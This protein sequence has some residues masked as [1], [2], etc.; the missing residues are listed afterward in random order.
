[1]NSREE[2]LAR[3]LSD[4]T[5]LDA[6]SVPALNSEEFPKVVVWVKSGPQWAT[7]K[8]SL[9]DRLRSPREGGRSLI[10]RLFRDEFGLNVPQYDALVSSLFQEFP[11]RFPL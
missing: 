9:V 10:K 3:L 6:G 1:M 4:F 8:P 11:H 2:Q 7:V 5:R